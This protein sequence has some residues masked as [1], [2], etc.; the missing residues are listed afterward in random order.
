[1]IQKGASSSGGWQEK[2]L[3]EWGKVIKEELIKNSE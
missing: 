2:D 3:K 1:M